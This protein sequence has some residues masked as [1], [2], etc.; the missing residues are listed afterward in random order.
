MRVDLDHPWWC[1]FGVSLFRTFFFFLFW[2][3]MKNLLQRFVGPL[4][5]F[6]LWE[7]G[8]REGRGG[9]FNNNKGLWDLW[10]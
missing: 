10:K 7:G 6:F 2:W 3:G 9:V 4:D 5:C 8:G 1:P